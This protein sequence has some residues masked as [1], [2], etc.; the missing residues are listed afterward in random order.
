MKNVKISVAIVLLFITLYAG[1]CKKPPLAERFYALIVYN[2]SSDTIV[3]YL[4]LGNGLTEYPDTSLPANRPAL[5]KIAPQRSFSYYSREPYED[6]IDNLAADTL[7][8]FILDGDVYRDSA[9]S[10]I[11]DKYLILKRYDV[12]VDYL[13]S[14]DWK[15]H[16]P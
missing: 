6:V 5:V 2:N 14:A 9:W 3:P 12:D 7:S 10:A 4:A 16:Y 11:R 8:I 13:K 1:R 15:I